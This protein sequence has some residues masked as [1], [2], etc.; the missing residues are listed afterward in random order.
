ML[1]IQHVS[2]L[3]TN[4][5]QGELEDVDILIDGSAIVRVGKNI[6]PPAGCQ[7]LPGTGLLGTPGLVNSHHHLYQV[8]LRAIP[9]LE[10][11]RIG[12][13]LAGLGTRCLKWWDRGTLTPDSVG[14]LAQAGMLESQLSG[15]TTVADQHYFHPSGKTHPFIE[16]TI[17][18]A[19]ALGMRMHAARGTLTLGSNAGGGAPEAMVQGID[20]VLRHSEE[21]INE[22]H[23]PGHHAMT[24]IALAPCGVHADRPELFDEFAQLAGDHPGVRLHTHLYEA[25]DSE[26]CR[27]RYGCSPWQFLQQHGW[28]TDQTWLAHVVDIPH[29]EIEELAQ[30]GVGVSHLIAPDLRMGF[31]FS[32]VREMLA[33]GVTVGFGT[34]GSASN[35]GSNV[36]GDLRVAALAHRVHYEDPEMWLTARELLY[37]ATRG[38]A[39]CL[40]REDLGVIAPG[41]AADLSF[42]DMSR[43]DR[44]GIHDPI[45][46][47]L[48][49]GISDIASIVIVN[50]RLVVQGGRHSRVDETELAHAAHRAFSRLNA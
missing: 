35:D 44:V 5:S 3:F 28:A 8:A 14:V 1:L 40:G 13:W 34:T 21:L 23:D 6:T 43:I 16:K 50:G 32:P 42:W 19:A 2:H 46:G 4:S 33:A 7:V 17:E 9:E 38:S 22:H 18:A 49:T 29:D 47:L 12:P 45:Q 11:A 26:F 36:L 10:R 48:M 39:L 25:V 24:R 37:A 20:E 31:G 30:A 27:R 15:V 41:Y